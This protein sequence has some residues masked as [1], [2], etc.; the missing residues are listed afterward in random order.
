MINILMS[1]Y[2]GEKYLKQQLDS[3]FAQDYQDF[4]L[5]VRDD[6]S[7]DNTAAIL[8]DYQK[9]ISDPGRMI[10]KEEKN[11]GFCE[12]FFE[13]L[14]M[15]DS[16]DYWAFCDQDDVWY[17]GKLRHALNWMEKQKK[18]IPLLYHSGLVFSDEA[19]NIKNDYSI[20][21]YKFDF[22]KAITS[23]IF[24]GFSMVIN[25]ELR[26]CLLQCDSKEILYHDWF[27]AMIATGFGKYYFSEDIDS[28]H[29]IHDA[30]TSPTNI[31][32]KLPL[33]KKLFSGD[34]FYTRNAIEY[35]KHFNANL[36]SDDQKILEL[37]DLRTNKWEKA[38]KKV[39]YPRRW[40]QRLPEEIGMRFFMLIGK[41]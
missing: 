15:S 21:G 35:K 4:T 18:E 38:V 2:N 1:T 27:A 6:G 19:L 13:L 16:G 26:D 7:K 14:R 17:N 39:F 23:N 40:N 11:V 12:S 37:F 25:R 41:I 20:N 32:K 5:Y 3:I 31:L 9:K 36:S 24:Y 29:R 33:I 22:Q 8:H 34:Q 30:N 28:I 10:I